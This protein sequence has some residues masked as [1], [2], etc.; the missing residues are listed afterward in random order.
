MKDKIS[1]DDPKAISDK[2]DEAIKWRVSNQLTEVE[3]FNTKQKEVKG[4]CNPIITKPHAD[5]GGMQ[6][7]GMG[8]AGG[9]PPLGDSSTRPW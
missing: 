6:T 7:W 5:S 9:A 1:K 2:R 8:G 4:V 3:E